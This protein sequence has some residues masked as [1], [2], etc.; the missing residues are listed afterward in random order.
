MS[1]IGLKEGIKNLYKI[2][3]NGSYA[4]KLENVRDLQQLEIDNNI[5]KS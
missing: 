5:N 2:N 4:D 1:P 3:I